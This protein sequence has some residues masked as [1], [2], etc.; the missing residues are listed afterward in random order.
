VIRPGPIVSESDAE[1]RHAQDPQN[2][3]EQRDLT[4]RLDRFARETIDEEAARLGVTVEELIAFA[5][6][7]YLADLDSGRIARAIPK[8]LYPGTAR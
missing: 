1:D 3:S 7:Y 8:S 6:L 4:L 5:V 2:T